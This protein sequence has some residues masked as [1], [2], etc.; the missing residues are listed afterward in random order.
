M[1][2]L[3]I[4]SSLKG[5]FATYVGDFHKR[6]DFLTPKLERMSLIH[7]NF[8]EANVFSVTKDA[9]I[10]TADMIGNIGGT[11]GVFI[12]FS[13]LGLLETLI[14][15]VQYLHQRRMSIKKKCSESTLEKESMTHIETNN[16]M[17][18]KVE[19]SHIEAFESK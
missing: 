14:D 2:L 8:E 7:I 16:V 17:S 1:N 19:P 15:M 9:K 12:G 5:F 11:L 18:T 10:T 4:S 13:F 3:I 6:K